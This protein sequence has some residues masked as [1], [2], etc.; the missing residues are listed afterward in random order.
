LWL[1]HT[2][3]GFPLGLVSVVVPVC[4]QSCDSTGRVW[5]G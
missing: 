2:A 4:G 1:F 5:R 3:C